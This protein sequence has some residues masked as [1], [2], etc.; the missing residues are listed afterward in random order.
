MKTKLRRKR[1]W[2]GGISRG[3]TEQ[4]FQE[5]NYRNGEEDMISFFP[6]LLLLP[7]IIY[8]S[9]PSYPLN[10]LDLSYFHHCQ[11]IM[12]K[13][14]CSISLT[15]WSICMCLFICNNF[16][17]MKIFHFMRTMSLKNMIIGDWDEVPE[18]AMEEA[19]VGVGQ[20]GMWILECARKKSKQKM[21]MMMIMMMMITSTK[22][23]LAVQEA[24]KKLG[25]RA[26]SRESGHLW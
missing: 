14:N 25:E 12:K 6:H 7:L 19:R 2:R 10:T 18:W 11:R 1:A 21:M 17:F 5:M 15:L 16:L 3:G 20:E 4:E 23:S 22:R 13:Q 9:S 24:P 26:G 8:Y